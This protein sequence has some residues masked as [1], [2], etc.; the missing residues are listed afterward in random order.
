MLSERETDGG[1]GKAF[2]KLQ[3][4]L[5]ESLQQAQRVSYRLLGNK[6]GKEGRLIGNEVS[7]SRSHR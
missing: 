4:L 3:Y 6:A 1:G 5:T 2:C 7:L